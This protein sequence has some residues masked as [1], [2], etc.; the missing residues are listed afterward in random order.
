MTAREGFELERRR[1]LGAILTDTF[2]LYF[3]HFPAFI[4]IGLAVVVPVEVVVLG[5]G[6]GELSGHYNST[7]TAA[8]EVIV[9]LT[10][11]LVVG[12]LVGLMVLYALL[13]LRGEQRP[14]VR[15]AIVSG[16][17][18]FRPAFLPVL[19]AA[20]IEVVTTPILIGIVFFFRWYFVPQLVA[21]ER[22]RG[23]EPLRAS[24]ELTRG[25]ALRTVAVLLATTIVFSLAGGIV[26]SPILSAA[27]SANTELLTLAA[28]VVTDV[29]TAAPVGIVAT[30]LLFDLRARAKP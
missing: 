14:R 21:L 18:T 10:R 25:N 19:I 28:Q 15:G 5:L 3:R 30:L 27:K 22:G 24:W 26:A 8:H 20:A 17:E 9:V 23:T 2:N 12:P 11:L 16:L 1:E 4:A 13:E 6:L 29:L 7:P